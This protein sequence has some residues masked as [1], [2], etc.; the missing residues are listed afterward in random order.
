[1]ITAEQVEIE[2]NRMLTVSFPEVETIYRNRYPQKFDRPSFLIETVK[3]DID[4]ANRK[5]V[6][7]VDHQHQPEKGAA[8]STILPSHALWRWTNTGT[9]RTA[10]CLRYK[11]PLCSFSARD[12]F[13]AG[14]AL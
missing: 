3:F 10:P 4:A 12:L 14:I 5:T 7:C 9:L 1:M 11:V 2:V 13:G 8:G 6:R